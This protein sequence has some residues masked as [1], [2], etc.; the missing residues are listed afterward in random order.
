MGEIVAY[1]SVGANSLAENGE[2]AVAAGILGLGKL[3]SP[4]TSGGSDRVILGK[5]HADGK[6]TPVPKDEESMT[7]CRRKTGPAP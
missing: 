6:D 1:V 7:P 4:Y 5:A 3:M 2:P